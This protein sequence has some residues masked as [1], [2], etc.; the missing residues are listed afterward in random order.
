MF[1]D[2]LECS[3]FLVL[4]TTHNFGILL[5]SN[6]PCS[7]HVNTCTR[8]M[9]QILEFGCF[10]VNIRRILAME[11]NIATIVILDIHK[12]SVDLALL[13]SVATLLGNFFR[14]FNLYL[15]FCHRI[16]YHT[17]FC[18]LEDLFKQCWHVWLY[19]SRAADSYAVARGDL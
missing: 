17:F 9:W 2:V 18:I 15:Q 12:K 8:Q 4:S 1:R 5:S 7:F 13:A 6:L 19:K 14:C 16:R 3:M 11:L 10:L